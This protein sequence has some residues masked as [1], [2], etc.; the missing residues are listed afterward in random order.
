VTRAVGW[1]G[2][3]ERP[4]RQRSRAA[5]IS[6]NNHD[7]AVSPISLPGKRSIGITASIHG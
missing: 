1:Q 3:G 2:H 7:G 5:Q 4:G 6:I